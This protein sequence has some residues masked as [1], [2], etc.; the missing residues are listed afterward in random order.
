MQA[1]DIIRAIQGLSTSIDSLGKLDLT[2]LAGTVGKA[3]ARAILAEERLQDEKL[4][5]AG[6]DDDRKFFRKRMELFE[7]LIHGYHEALVFYS[8]RGNWDIVIDPERNQAINALT[9]GWE[10][11]EKAIEEGL[12][13]AESLREHLQGSSE[14]IRNKVFAGK[15]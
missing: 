3:E 11:A 15:S 12:R 9:S 10:R 13:H 14:S 2:S 4:K 1:D 8:T 7:N 5:T 6:T